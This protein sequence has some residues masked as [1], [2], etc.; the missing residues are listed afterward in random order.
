MTTEVYLSA[1][2][3]GNV[4]ECLT[5]RTTSFIGVVDETTIL[6]YPLVPGDEK[7]LATLGFEARMLQTIGPDKHII[8]FKGLTERW[9]TP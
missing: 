8:G 3:P 1:Y 9:F 7:G 2:C 6:K 5:R 4:T